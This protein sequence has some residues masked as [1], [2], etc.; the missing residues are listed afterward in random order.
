MFSAYR[1][2]PFDQKYYELF[3]DPKLKV[4]TPKTKA[5]YV[6]YFTQSFPH[7]T[8][9]TLNSNWMF[10]NQKVVM[11]LVARDKRKGHEQRSKQVTSTEIMLQPGNPPILSRSCVSNCISGLLQVKS[12]NNTECKTPVTK[13]DRDQAYKLTTLVQNF[14]PGSSYSYK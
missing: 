8:D 11:V 10:E 14:I 1:E 3:V 4:R 2:H 5:E 12:K 7:V 9:V 6:P 13:I